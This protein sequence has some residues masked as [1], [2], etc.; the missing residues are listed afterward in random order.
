[1]IKL[2][3][4]WFKKSFCWNCNK[5]LKS[6]KNSFCNG[7]CAH[8]YEKRFYTHNAIT[9]AEEWIKDNSGREMEDSVLVIQKLLKYIEKNK[10]ERDLV[11]ARNEY[12]IR[13]LEK[14]IDDDKTDWHGKIEK[15]SI[16]SLP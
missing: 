9:L 6:N 1:M 13:C 7:L 5:A 11:D 14:I 4:R 10:K 3:Q 2:I 16:P 12:D 8:Y 15:F